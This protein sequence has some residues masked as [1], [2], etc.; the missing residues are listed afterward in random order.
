MATTQDYIEFVCDQ[1]RGD[2]DVRSKKMFGEYMV[3]INGKPVLL[4]CD[5][6]VFVKQLD[7]VKDLMAEAEVGRPYES[8]KEHYILDVEDRERAA[9]VITAL[10]AVTPVPKP[11]KKKS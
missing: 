8:A 7:S 1:V 4:V 11:R 3:Y 9:R 2:W 10:E 6:T 5:N